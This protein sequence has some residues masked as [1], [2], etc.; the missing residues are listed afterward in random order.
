MVKFNVTHSID[1]T[2][3]VHGGTYF[4]FHYLCM[5]VL[6]RGTLGVT[7]IFF[8]YDNVLLFQREEHMVFC[9]QLAHDMESPIIVGW[10]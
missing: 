4:E 10:L 8:P 5:G 6:S 1:F 3:I 9:I 2:S 7:N